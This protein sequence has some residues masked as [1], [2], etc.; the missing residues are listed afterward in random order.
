MGVISN[1]D[2]NLPRLRIWRPVIWERIGAVIVSVAFL[3]FAIALVVSG[4][5]VEEV[6]YVG[7][8]AFFTVSG[9]LFAVYAVATSLAMTK[10]HLI[11]RNLGHRREVPIGKVQSVRPSYYGTEIR[12]E[13]GTWFYSLAIQRPRISEWLGRRAR[14]DEMESSVMSAARRAQASGE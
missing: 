13:N 9:V 8:C 12:C 3:V 10:S 4:T 1:S 2:E 6:A 11:V 14:S 7:L 5:V